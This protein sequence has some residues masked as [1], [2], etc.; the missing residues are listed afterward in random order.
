MWREQIRMERDNQRMRT[1]RWDH[2]GVGVPPPPL[3][4]FIP[5]DRCLAGPGMR[6][7]AKEAGGGGG[8][9]GREWGRP[10]DGIKE[11]HAVASDSSP[12]PPPPALSLL[13]WSGNDRFHSC[14]RSQ[15]GE[16]VPGYR[17]G[18]RGAEVELRPRMQGLVW[19]AATLIIKM[20][21]V[22]SSKTRRGNLSW[23]RQCLK[24]VYWIQERNQGCLWST[25]RSGKI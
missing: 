7:S 24:S 5:A 6:V 9:E 22:T 23:E 15:R 8:R 1:G 18:A 16:V 14:I 4:N 12:P 10:S 3:S 21:N 19:I 2:R 17:G 13:R 20:R 25:T 11:G